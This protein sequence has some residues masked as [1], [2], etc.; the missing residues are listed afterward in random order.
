MKSFQIALNIS[1]I[2]NHQQSA[3][4]ARFVANKPQWLLRHIGGI[5]KAENGE[6]KHCMVKAISRCVFPGWN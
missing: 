4:E 5:T 3:E 2:E 6:I 1:L